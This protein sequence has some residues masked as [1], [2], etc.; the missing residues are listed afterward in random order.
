MG[1]KSEVAYSFRAM[2]ARESRVV[3][4]GYRHFVPRGLYYCWRTPIF[5][6]S[7]AMTHGHFGNQ[8]EREIMRD[9][10]IWWGQA[11]YRDG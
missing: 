11:R 9:P 3:V 1:R 5:S 8:Q 4:A 6:D 10:G 7:R 2:V